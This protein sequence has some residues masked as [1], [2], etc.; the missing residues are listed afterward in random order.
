MLIAFSGPVAGA[1]EMC[2]PVEIHVLESP[3]RASNLSARAGELSAGNSGVAENLSP[4]LLPPVNVYIAVRVEC[5]IFP[6]KT[7][8]DRILGAAGVKLNIA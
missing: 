5:G 3:T 8:A 6:I 2:A 4:H 1:S 7:R